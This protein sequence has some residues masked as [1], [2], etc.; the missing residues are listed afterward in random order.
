MKDDVYYTHRV[1]LHISDEAYTALALSYESYISP[2]D[3]AYFSDNSSLLENIFEIYVPEWDISN[4]EHNVTKADLYWGCYTNEIMA[5]DELLEF[6]EY[7]NSC[8]VEIYGITYRKNTPGFITAIN[9]EHEPTI[10]KKCF[11]TV[12]GEI[13][14]VN[15]TDAI[16]GY[17]NQQLTLTHK[18]KEYLNMEVRFWENR[19]DIHS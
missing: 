17:E 7:L 8:G 15:F 12:N 2:Y 16:K 5:Y 14:T 13:K 9:L 4:P 6:F 19:I 1:H 11:K 18:H 3:V 10:V